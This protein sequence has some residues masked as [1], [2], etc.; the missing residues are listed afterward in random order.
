[1]DLK[2][3]YA[4]LES[5]SSIKKLDTRNVAKRDTLEIGQF[6]EIK[7]IAEP[8]AVEYWIARVRTLMDFF[9]KNIKL[10]GQIQT[11]GKGQKK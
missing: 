4:Y 6:I 2:T 10:F 8:P 3:L 7:G 9:E 1:M 11:K 5:E